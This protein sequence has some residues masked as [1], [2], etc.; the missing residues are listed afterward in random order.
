MDVFTVQF[1]VGAASGSCGPG[2]PQCV[3]RD[4]P[5]FPN[6]KCIGPWERMGILE[7]RSENS[8]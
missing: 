5:P 8:G 3:W 1:L 4:F 6:H 7:V 2:A